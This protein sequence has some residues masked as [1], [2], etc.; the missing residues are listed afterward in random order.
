MAP[1][2]ALVFGASGLI[3]R[4]LI[5]AL[6][7]AGARVTATVRSSGSAAKLQQWLRG[8]GLEQPI[9]TVIV[10]FDATDLLP[11]GTAAFGH[12]TEIHNC[13]GT[14]RFG[15]DAQEARSAN[16]GIVE[17]LMRFAATLPDL[18]RVV[19][20][21]GYRVGGQDPSS[22]PYTAQQRRHLYRELGAYEASKVESDAIFQ[23]LG[24]ELSIP[25]TV[26]NPASVIGH[27]RTGES[28]QHIGLAGTIEQLWQGKTSALPA[29]ES[30]FV[31][32][33]TVDYMAAF[34]AAVPTDPEAA[35]NSYWLLDDA[36]PPLGLMLTDVGRHL[37]VKLPSLR[38]PVRM[39]K[40]LPS[41][42]TKVDP[43]ILSFMSTDRY[44]TQTALE[45][46]NRHGV[47]MPD[48]GI[49][50]RRWADYMAAHRFGLAPA[51]GRRFADI[52]G[53]RTFEL[54]EPS[55]R[56]LVLP[57]IPGNADSWADVALGIGGRAVDLPGLGLSGGAGL[58]DWDDWLSALLDSEP[59]D[60]VGHSMGAAAA[61]T[62]AARFRNKVRSLTLIAPFFL[63]KPAGLASKM[64]PAVRWYLRHVT[65]GQLSRHLTGSDGGAPTLST[66]VDDL[67]RSSAKAAAQYLACSGSKKWRA[68]LRQTLNSF[69][70]QLR[71]IWG[72]NDPL[73]PSV[74]EHLD[75]RSDTELHCISGAGHHP[76]L[77]HQQALI[78]LLH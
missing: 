10:D 76:Q 4:H 36:T 51:T 31:P 9:D 14:F 18:Q 23:A 20:I 29:G 50:I 55:A 67:R 32:V 16:V 34:M 8:H 59:V 70:G 3:G 75:G 63:Q 61:L 24:Q 52:G 33:L 5:L 28:D 39:I 38:L 57:G 60:L 6:V 2:H 54:G 21:S 40:A 48:A 45:F 65:A 11:G 66:S 46:A 72:E 42:A 12:I 62:A 53:I 47:Q 27:S 68:Q 25:W 43:E 26:V 37:G 73:L 30:T 49:S 78:E 41:W 71:I 1:R 58:E 13:A 77:T 69:D 35:G 56:K 17:K 19:H 64:T 74:L 44:P 7:Q 22:V 15:M